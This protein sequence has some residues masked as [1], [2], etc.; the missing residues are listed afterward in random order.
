MK[1]AI[2]DGQRIEPAPKLK[3]KCPL[4]ASDV[5]AKCGKE[6]V[7]HWAHKTT[8]HCDHWWEPEKE[9]HR[10]WKNLFPTDWQE[11]RRR[12]DKGELHIADV[13]TPQG[14]ALEF[15]HSA[16]PR[17]EIEARVAFHKEICW[18]VDGLRLKS[19]I[20]QFKEALEHARMPNSS[21]T[22]VFEIFYY[23][24]RL[25]KKWSGLNAPV[26]F[27]F[28]IDDLWVIGR[29]M[30]NSALMYTLERSKLVEQ[31]IQGNRPPP[32]QIRAPQY[33]RSYRKRR[34]GRRF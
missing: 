19:S 32:V 10:N 8:K 14:L 9:W 27:D 31:L 11:Q 24:S 29:S 15:Q 20:T 2:L 7:W 33:K 34:V 4:C 30:Q 18:I 17:D 13:L 28:G 21:G 6:R 26:V 16:I 5:L 1:F 3:A 25:L 22:T 23:D 12:D